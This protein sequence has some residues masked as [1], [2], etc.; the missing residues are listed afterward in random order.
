MAGLFMRILQFYEFVFITAAAAF[1]FFHP[2]AAA[3][4]IVTAQPF[5]PGQPSHAVMQFHR[6]ARGHPEVQHGEQADEEFFHRGKIS[7]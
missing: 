3:T 7:K 5:N 4:I 2:A 6:D 1:F